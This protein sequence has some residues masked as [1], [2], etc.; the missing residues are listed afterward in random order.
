MFKRCCFEFDSR[1]NGSCGGVNKYVNNGRLS[2]YFDRSEIIVLLR[3]RRQEKGRR[4]P[5]GT[6]LDSAGWFC[7]ERAQPLD[8]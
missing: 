4:A 1:V 8:Q 6:A 7:V 2:C 5:E 3:A